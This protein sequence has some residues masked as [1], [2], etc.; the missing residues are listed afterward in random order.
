MGL[1]FK[2]SVEALKNKDQSICITSHPC[3]FLLW[4]CRRVLARVTDSLY[5]LFL[6]WH[7]R[8]HH[9]RVQALAVAPLFE[10]REGRSTTL[11]TAPISL[12]SKSTSAIPRFTRLTNTLN[13]KNTVKS[14]NP[15]RRRPNMKHTNHNAKKWHV[16]MHQTGNVASSKSWLKL[17]AIWSANKTILILIR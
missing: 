2:R 17:F 6:E 10:T 16:T 13:S 12:Y 11:N 3:K 7:V 8:L 14:S 1:S 15:S 5:R 9:W 4:V